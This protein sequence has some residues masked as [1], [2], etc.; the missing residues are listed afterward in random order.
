MGTREAIRVADHPHPELVF[1]VRQPERQRKVELVA[2][3]TAKGHVAGDGVQRPR[4]LLGRI[5]EL[6]EGRR[7]LGARRDSTPADEL[8]SHLRAQRESV[9]LRVAP[10]CRNR[11]LRRG[12]HDQGHR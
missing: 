11:T 12:N 7:L 4:G 10:S 5:D 8:L 3:H 1:P 2:D 9:D 6:G